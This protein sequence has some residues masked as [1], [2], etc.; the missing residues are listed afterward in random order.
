[1]TSP[2][3]PCKYPGAC[4]CDEG[5]NRQQGGLPKPYYEDDAVKIYLGDCRDVLPTLGRVDLVLTD[6]PFSEKTHSEARTARN[7]GFSSGDT[8]RPLITFE[9]LDYEDICERLAMTDTR[10][11]LVAFMDW[12]YIARLAE[13][14]LP[15]YRFVRFG[16]WVKPNSAP[17]FTGDRPAQGWEGIAFLHWEDEKLCWNGGGSRAVWTYPK[18]P[19]NQHPTQKPEAL[20]RELIGLFSEVG[21]LILDPFMGSG[22]TLRAAKDLGRKAI[23]IEIEE[24]YCEIAANRMS[25]AVLPL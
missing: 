5:V 11:W 10:R 22:T 9:P 20:I 3:P 1:M 12:R 19:N 16:V 8:D 13:V 21:D 23:G 4:V 14:P 2:C 17:Q 7:Y 6:P 15:D 25:Q 24:K 18:E